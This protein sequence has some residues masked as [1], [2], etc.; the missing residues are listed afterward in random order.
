M[1]LLAH[2]LWNSMWAFVITFRP[3]AVRPS[4]IHIFLKADNS[5]TIW[6]IDL[7]IEYVLFEEKSTSQK[8]L[9]FG[10]L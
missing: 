8:I 9:Y 6:A 1:F 2:Q 4:T 7:Q 3:S 10:L 5:K